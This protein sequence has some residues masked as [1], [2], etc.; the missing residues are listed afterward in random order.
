M[1]RS[2]EVTPPP[3]TRAARVR[4]GAAPSGRH[5]ARRNAACYLLCLLT[6]AAL[7][8]VDVHYP[9]DTTP[10]SPVRTVL[11]AVL[12]P[13]TSAGT[14]AAGAVTGYTHALVRP[15]HTA[16]AEERLR[17]EN[18]QLRAEAFA[19]ADASAVA[20]QVGDL[21]RRS[22]SA[23]LTVVP[24]RVVAFGPEQGFERT[25]TLDHGTAD[26]IATGAA[27]VTGDGLAG[28][29]LVAQAASSTVLLLCDARSAVGVRIGN[30]GDLALARGTGTCDGLVSV[31]RLRTDPGL[32]AGTAVTTTGSL[33]D[34]VFP[35]ALPVGTIAGAA[36]SASTSGDRGVV[37]VRLAAAP[38]A[39]DVVGV[40]RR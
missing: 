20:A 16:A 35:P 40:V 6:C 29:V 27:V 13:L 21:L 3:A 2:R 10:L 36:G 15:A 23:G 24:A 34:S 26:G 32:A 12:A 18:A 30:S 9:G 38:A 4:T 37:Q 14:R 39:L 5:D 22:G 17:R 19:A 11:A 31:S 8:T 28:R 1:P 7:V 33:P 25:V